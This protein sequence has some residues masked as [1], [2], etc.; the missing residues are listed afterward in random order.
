MMTVEHGTLLVISIGVAGSENLVMLS[1][2]SYLY[3]SWPFLNCV[4]SFISTV[5]FLILLIKVESVPEF[6]YAPVNV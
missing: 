3:I 2:N 1:D 5:C 6:Y 4:A